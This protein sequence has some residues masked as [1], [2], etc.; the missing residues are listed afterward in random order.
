MHQYVQDLQQSAVQ[1][2]QL[3]AQILRIGL[4]KDTIAAMDL[5]L[6]RMD[7]RIV[8]M[9]AEMSILWQELSILESHQESY[10]ISPPLQ[11]TTFSSEIVAF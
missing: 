3:R 5:V 1:Q 4:D 8:E 7:R 9:G 6:S 10:H 2:T 11:Q